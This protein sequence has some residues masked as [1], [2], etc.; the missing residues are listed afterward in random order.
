MLTD[1]EI[2][3]LVRK[4][5]AR[6]KSLD[7][8]LSIQFVGEK[9]IRELNKKYRGVNK[10]T[11]VLSFSFGGEDLGDI[12]ICFSQIKRQ[13]KIY[14]VPVKEEVARILTH[15][16]LHLLGFDH[17]NK[18]DEKKMLGLQEKLIRHFL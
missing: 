2:R 3:G 1:T 13:A 9:K 8:I 4:I 16:V 6:F 18:S 14:Q 12:F 7:K 11:D 15:G 5:L 17:Q 10:V